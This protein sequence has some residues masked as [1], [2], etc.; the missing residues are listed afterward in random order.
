MTNQLFIV[1]KDT[2]LSHFKS[3]GYWMLVLSPLIFI[4]CAGAIF[5]GITKM[6]GNTT[7]NIAVIGNQEIRRIL[8]KSEKELDIH[9]SKLTNRQ[10]ANRALQNEKLDGILTVNDDSATITTQPKSNQIPKE[11]ITAILGNLSR[12]KKATSYG[13]TAEQTAD[14]V[15]NFNL[16]TVVKQATKSNRTGN[17]ETANQLLASAIGIITMVIVMW[18]TS[19]IANA[20]ANEKSSRI[21]EILLAATSARVQYFGKIIGIFGLVLTHLIIYVV[22]SFAGFNFFKD[23]SFVKILSTNLSGVTLSFVIYAVIFILVAVALYL[24]LTS[25]IASLINDNAQVQQAIQPI[26]MIAMIGYFFS[27]IMT[28]MPN[29]L[30]IRIL[31]YVPFIS[32]TMMPVRL[33]TDTEGWPAAIIA[34]LLAIVTLFLLLWFGQGMYAKNVLSY[35]DESIMKQLTASFRKNK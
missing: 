29:N 14:L 15:Q 1:I 6:Q 20:I 17:S 11:E 25:M 19:M 22:T 27:F 31:S 28:Q 2:F 21:M 18:Y 34:L 8:V 7:P 30:L 4:A 16:K 35:S 23:N 3:R 9:V 33:V 5:F 12:S 26:S 24:V 13:L 10:K 32:Q